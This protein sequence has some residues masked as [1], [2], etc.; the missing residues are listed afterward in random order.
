MYRKAAAAFRS[1][2]QRLALDL[3]EWAKRDRRAMSGFVDD[4]LRGPALRFTE[5]DGRA[6]DR[7]RAGS[8]RSRGSDLSESDQMA[9]GAARGQNFPERK[10]ID[11]PELIREI[12]I[13][14][15]RCALGYRESSNRS[16]YEKCGKF[17]KGFKS[18]CILA[19][20]V[21]C[22]IYR[23][24]DFHGIRPAALDVVALTEQVYA[25]VLRGEILVRKEFDWIGN[26]WAWQGP[27]P[28][29]YPNAGHVGILVDGTMVDPTA[30]QLCRPLSGLKVPDIVVV[31]V[32]K[33]SSDTYTAV[34]F[35][36]GE[37]HLLYR[38][39]PESTQYLKTPEWNDRELIDHIAD[40]VM[41]DLHT[42][43]SAE[44]MPFEFLSI[45]SSVSGT[46]I[47]DYADLTPK[48]VR[49][50]ITEPYY[51]MFVKGK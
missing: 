3:A 48:H 8:A 42:G 43:R 12:S 17:A 33:L 34:A 16:Y 39:A 27:L 50:S 15:N 2:T 44:P 31:P 18:K 45:D 25:Q 6:G 1:L 32:D 10:S 38:L 35:E 29:G 28:Y 26:G 41:E 4:R 13:A 14:I 30:G 21:G 40:V 20:A 11:D 47:R 22:E 19:T 46:R 23:R 7:V 5:R 24:C 51:Q 9:R 37:T 49:D 36:D